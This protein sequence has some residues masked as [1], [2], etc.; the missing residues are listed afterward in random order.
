M[1][2]PDPQRRIGIV[3]F[4][5]KGP[6]G[7]YYH[8]RFVTTLLND[9]FGIQSRA[10]CSCAGPYGH[11]L[12]GIDDATAQAYRAVIAEGH[13]GIKPG[14]CRIGFHY[15]FD[16]TD[17]DYL[18]Q[19]VEFIAERGYCFLPLYDFESDTGVWRHQQQDQSPVTLSLAEALNAEADKP[20]ALSEGNVVNSMPPTWRPPTAMPENWPPRCRQPIDD[21]PVR[22]GHCSF[23]SWPGSRW[24]GDKSRR[25]LTGR[26]TLNC[27]IR[28]FS[29]A[30]SVES[31]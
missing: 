12:L 3:S 4:N 23:F 18:L 8:P 28:P 7:R 19:A 6:G 10:G 31:C 20:Q 14:W 11:K 21:S 2:N 22:R 24:N 16:Q 17:V 5:L 13:C 30:A 29:S 27:P 26:Y 1:G 9:L 15:L 25:S